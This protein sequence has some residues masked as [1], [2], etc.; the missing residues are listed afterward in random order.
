MYFVFSQH[1][2]REALSAY[3]TYY[4]RW[5]WNGE[6]R[7]V[8]RAL[9]LSKDAERSLRNLSSASSTTFMGLLSDISV[10]CALHAFRHNGIEHMDDE[11]QG[12]AR[13]GMTRARRAADN[14]AGSGLDPSMG[15]SDT[16]WSWSSFEQADEGLSGRLL[17]IRRDCTYQVQ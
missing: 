7:A 14:C 11:E 16:R 3:V 4:N 5:R 10:F 8:R 2:L 9:C 12:Y 6:L 1:D 15:T 13:W 17:N